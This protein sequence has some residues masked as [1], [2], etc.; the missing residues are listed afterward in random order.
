MDLAFTRQLARSIPNGAVLLFDKNLRYLLAEGAA[1]DRHGFDPTTMIGKRVDEVLP[2]AALPSLLPIYE[3]TIAGESTQHTLE[4][5]SGTFWTR[6]EPL[7]EDGK[8]QAGMVLIVEVSE[9]ERQ[10][11]ELQDYFYILSHDIKSPLSSILGLLQVYRLEKHPDER[12]RLLDMMEQMA[13]RSLAFITALLDQTIAPIDVQSMV[14]EIM[15]KAAHQYADRAITFRS[16]YQYRKGKFYS[17]PTLLRSVLENLLINAHKYYDP[18]KPEPFVELKVREENAHV[19]ITVADNG[20]GIAAA[21]LPHIFEKNYQLDNHSEG[22]GYGLYLVRQN[23]HKLGGTIRADSQ[24]GRGTTF[25][26]TI[27]KQETPQS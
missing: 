14:A 7:Y 6:F 13:Q 22:H 19:I 18:E 23:L 24:P 15:E 8:W 4:S 25:T 27:P 11:K 26:L 17:V 1:L 20:L 21:D 2:S 16:E 5:A 3:K 10:K 12:E 9:L